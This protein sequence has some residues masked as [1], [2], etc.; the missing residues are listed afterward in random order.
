MSL[1]VHEINNASCLVLYALSHKTVLGLLTTLRP[2]ENNCGMNERAPLDRCTIGQ[3]FS[4][5]V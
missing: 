1:M 2:R 5:E 3:S 4:Y